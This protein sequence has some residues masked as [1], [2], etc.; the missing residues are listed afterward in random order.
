MA[1]MDPVKRVFIIFHAVYV[2]GFEFQDDLNSRSIF[3]P[4]SYENYQKSI[5][6]MSVEIFDELLLLAVQNGATIL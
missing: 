2:E 6:P 5:E 3:K 4:F 1:V